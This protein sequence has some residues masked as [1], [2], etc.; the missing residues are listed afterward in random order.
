MEELRQEEAIN[1]LSVKF[2]FFFYNL[3]VVNICSPFFV[4]KIN[5]IFKIIEN[6]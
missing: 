5:I 6:V 1:F 2:E 3:R 4:K